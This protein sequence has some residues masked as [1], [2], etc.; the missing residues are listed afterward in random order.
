MKENLH[1][2]NIVVKICP[3][4]CTHSNTAIPQK[5]LIPE[6]TCYQNGKLV[7]ENVQRLP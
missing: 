3:K 6:G 5:I 7:V 4:F 2:E 1:I